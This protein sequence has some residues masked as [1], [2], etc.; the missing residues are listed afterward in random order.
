MEKSTCAA[1]G[2]QFFVR[3]L[4]LPVL[5]KQTAWPRVSSS[6]LRERLPAASLPS[7]SPFSGLPF[8]TILSAPFS[9]ILRSIM[10]DGD[11]RV[12]VR[13]LKR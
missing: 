10:D 11:K 9:H 13:V 8:F 4:S 6:S 2:P 5:A 1:T 3:R 12:R 7:T